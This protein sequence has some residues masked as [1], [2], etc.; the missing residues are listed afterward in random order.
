MLFFDGKPSMSAASFLE[1]ARRFLVCEDFELMRGLLTEEDPAPESGNALRD[2]LAR[3]D[4]GFRNELV[5]HRAHRLNKDP[6]AFLRGERALEPFWTEQIHQALKTE[7]LLD[8]Q[9]ALDKIRWQF[10]EDLERGHFF[11]LETLLVY[12]LKLKILERRQQYRS[13]QG[14]EVFRELRN[15]EFPKTSLAASESKVSL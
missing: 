8:A 12:G 9:D 4:R 13:P 15:M 2:A 5:W 7:N 11:D 6:L 14:K 3:F 10:L 1:D